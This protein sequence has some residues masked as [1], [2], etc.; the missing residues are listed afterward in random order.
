M[1]GLLAPPLEQPAPLVRPLGSMV[2]RLAV[3][4]VARRM[5]RQ[6]QW[7]VGHLV[8]LWPPLELLVLLASPLGRHCPLAL[9]PRWTSAAPFQTSC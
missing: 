8:E 2:A 7:P 3:Q 4:R 1:L 9:A 6:P 5:V